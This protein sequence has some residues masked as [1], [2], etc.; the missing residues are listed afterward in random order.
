MKSSR[1]DDWTPVRRLNLNL[2]YPLDAI[3]NARTL[4]EAGRRVHL[5]QS[6][7]SHALRRLRE[8]FGDDIVAHLG[9][10]QFLTPLGSAL[11]P[12]VRRLMREIEGTFNYI[13]DFDPS[14]SEAAIG[15]AATSAVEQLLLGPLMQALAV[16][17]PGISLDLVPINLALPLAA[18]ER[19]AD[20]LVLPAHAAS[21]RLISRPLLDDAIACLVSRT[22][23]M[24]GTASAISEMDYLAARHIVAREDELG[25]VMPAGGNVQGLLGKRKI[26][27]RASA[28]AAI[29]HVV[30]RSDLVATGSRRLFAYYAANL[31]VRVLPL[32][33]A[34]QTIPVVLQWAAHRRHDPAL[35]WLA[36]RLELAAEATVLAG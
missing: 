18:M 33:A 21:E 9:G 12:E 30:A 11:R 5:S 15:I 14:T 35:A 26:V 16:E 27:A 17:A 8:Y 20:M 25:V 31:P 1:D 3:L 13:V 6:A 32:A 36:R 23:P 19:G 24:F 7:M 10:D 29:P 2:L 34:T 22:H 4:T 28:E